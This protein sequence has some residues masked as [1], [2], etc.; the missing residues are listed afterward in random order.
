[1]NLKRRARNLAQ[2]DSAFQHRLTW[3]DRL[4]CFRAYVEASA[5]ISDARRFLKRIRIQSERRQ[6]HNL[7]ALRRMLAQLKPEDLGTP[8][9]PKTSV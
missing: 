2:L 8:K 6:S 3:T 9:S 5:D 7:Q 4:R 1:V